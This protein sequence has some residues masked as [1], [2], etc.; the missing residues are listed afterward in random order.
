MS[1]FF[2]E[3]KLQ[4]NIITVQILAGILQQILFLLQGKYVYEHNF[5][6][7]WR[8]IIILMV[9]FIRWFFT[10]L[11]VTATKSKINQDIL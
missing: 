7:S 11:V 8:L 3:G 6:S 9:Q 5:A 1:N 2:R 10:F 4:L